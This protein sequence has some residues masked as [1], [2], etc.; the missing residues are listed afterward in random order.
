MVSL[1]LPACTREIAPKPG[2]WRDA[3]ANSRPNR[4]VHDRSGLEVSPAPL[5]ECSP[6][7]VAHALGL[8]DGLHSLPCRALRDDRR[9]GFVAGGE[10]RGPATD[11]FRRIY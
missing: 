1:S 7:T 4:F 8:P 9:M 6:D 10:Q 2:L 5:A 3:A 11:M